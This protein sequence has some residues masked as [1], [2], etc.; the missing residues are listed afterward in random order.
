MFESIGH[1]I[2]DSTR[3]VFVSAVRSRAW[4]PEGGMAEEIHGGVSVEATA[5]ARLSQ[6]WHKPHHSCLAM[7]APCLNLD[8]C[9]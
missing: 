3:F 2:P 5:A 8:N 4:E 1:D 9:A 6:S 7:E